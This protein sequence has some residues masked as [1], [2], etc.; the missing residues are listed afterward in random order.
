MGAMPCEVQIVAPVEVRAEIERWAAAESRCV[1]RLE[2]AASVTDAGV[3]IAAVDENGLRRERVVASAQ[4]A[5]ALVMSWAADDDLDDR[6]ALEM[7]S[8]DAPELPSLEGPARSPSPMRV[9]IGA[10]AGA[11]SLGIAARV[12]L[13]TRGGFNF[14]VAGDIEGGLSH[15]ATT[16]GGGDVFAAHTWTLGRLDV[17]AQLGV[18]ARSSDHMRGADVSPALEVSGALRLRLGETWAVYAGPAASVT[19]DALLLVGVAGVE[20]RR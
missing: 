6:V 5:A 2:V 9:A 13:F 11:D 18:G 15:E 1:H 16:G 17:R 8:I 20:W 4:T 12:D 19:P 7:P 3:A 10:L 14:G